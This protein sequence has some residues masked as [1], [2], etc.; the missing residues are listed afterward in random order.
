MLLSGSYIC[1]TE[2]KTD[3]GHYHK[4]SHKYGAQ[5]SNHVTQAAN[6]CDSVHTKYLI[7]LAKHLPPVYK[8]KYSL[9]TS[10]FVDIY[11]VTTLLC[12]NV[13]VENIVKYTIYRYTQY[14]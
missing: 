4:R 8:P 9:L 6:V 12:M 14:Y 1:K 7:T 11:N 2:W 10:L 3:Q 5:R 13:F